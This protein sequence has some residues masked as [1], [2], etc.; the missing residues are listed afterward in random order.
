MAKQPDRSA[1]M[2]RLP[3]ER[4]Q[5]KKGHLR[6]HTPKWECQ[7]WVLESHPESVSALVYLGQRKRLGIVQTHRL[8]LGSEHQAGRYSRWHSRRTIRL[9]HERRSFRFST[10]PTQIRFAAQN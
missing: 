5:S 8:A 2:R 1:A 6:S 3:A 7:N 10:D 4:C 9:R